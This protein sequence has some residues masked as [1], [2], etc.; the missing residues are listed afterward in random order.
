MKIWSYSS[1]FETSHHSGLSDVS[2]TQEKELKKLA[3]S[4]NFKLQPIV[5]LAKDNYITFILLIVTLKTKPNHDFLVSL[6]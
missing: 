1:K 5:V 4:F 2:M 6:K 3:N